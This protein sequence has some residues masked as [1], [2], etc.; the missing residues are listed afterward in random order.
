MNHNQIRKL[1]QVKLKYIDLWSPEAEELIFLT[2]L[3]ESGYDY[4]RQLGDGPAVSFF[5]VEPATAHD[6]CVNY[7]KYRATRLQK[8]CDATKIPED[9][10]KTS[11]KQYWADMLW[12]NIAAGILF[13]RYKYYRVPEPIPKEIEGMA[14]YW[15][16]H[17]NT[18]GGKGSVKHFLE[19]AK[20]R[21]DR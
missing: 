4:I 3:T 8:F 15:K 7:L 6:V 12:Y 11:Y 13:C 19:L 17:Y 20:R 2:G 21:E 5:Q 9:A 14:A 16:E 1:I 10:I 18:A